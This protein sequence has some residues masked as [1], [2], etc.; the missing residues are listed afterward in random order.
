MCLTQLS[1]QPSLVCLA[2]QHSCN[3]LRAPFYAH[4]DNIRLKIRFPLNLSLKRE[5]GI[6]A[7]EMCQ[8]N[9]CHTPLASRP[10]T[11]RARTVSRGWPLT[12]FGEILNAA[13]R[14]RDVK[15]ANFS[16]CVPNP[17]IMAHL[18]LNLFHFQGSELQGRV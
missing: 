14:F 17:S 3:V 4:E 9:F 2:E 10:M 15:V 1:E 11:M 18:H 13:R 16:A 8:K 5:H 12:S 6:R 7:R